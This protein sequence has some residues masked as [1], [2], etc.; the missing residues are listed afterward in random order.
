MTVRITAGNIISVS[1]A[2][3]PHPRPRTA[4]RDA[5]K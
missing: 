3:G 4:L 5:L 2:T 1:A